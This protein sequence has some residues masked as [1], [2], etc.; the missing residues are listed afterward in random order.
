MHMV[1]DELAYSLSV[2]CHDEPYRSFQAQNHRVQTRRKIHLASSRVLASASRTGD[3]RDLEVV[4]G[5]VQVGL[6]GF[7]QLQ[8]RLAY[9]RSSLK[10]TQKSPSVHQNRVMF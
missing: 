5:E 10:N 4:R 7:R 3:S 6:M 2:Q 9:Q 8:W 1:L